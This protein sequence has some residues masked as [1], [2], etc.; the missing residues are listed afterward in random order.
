[1]SQWRVIKDARSGEIVLA[2]A[3]SCTGFF[4]RLKGL[5]FARALPED[6]GLLFANRSE[7]RLKAAVHTFF[8]SFSIALVWLDKDGVVIDK[9][10][11]KPWRPLYIPK[12]PAMYYIEAH[13]S[14]LERVETGDKLIFDEVI[15]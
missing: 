7:S 6:E 2:R 15:F 3:G 11:A 14:L 4:C 10:C 9:T 5:Q 12:L 1:M 8:M 13:P